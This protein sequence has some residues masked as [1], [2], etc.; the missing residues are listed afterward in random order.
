MSRLRQEGMLDVAAM[1]FFQLAAK[2]IPLY[3]IVNFCKKATRCQGSCFAIFAVGV[4]RA[5]VG[6]ARLA[7]Q[8]SERWW[9]QPT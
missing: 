1:S 2:F 7:P 5:E 4:V 9:A 6:I 8:A 3:S